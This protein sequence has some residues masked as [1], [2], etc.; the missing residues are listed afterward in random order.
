MSNEGNRAELY[1]K[2]LMILGDLS[3]HHEVFIALM[4]PFE[5][6]FEI[7]RDVLTQRLSEVNISDETF[8]K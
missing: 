8:E 5:L 4:P 2:V 1:G 3:E 6:S 7:D